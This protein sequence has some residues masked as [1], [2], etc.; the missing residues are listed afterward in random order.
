MRRSEKCLPR[1]GESGPRPAGATAPPAVAGGLW[2]DSWIREDLRSG[3]EGA[4]PK[5][6]RNRPT[7]GEP[8]PPSGGESGHWRRGTERTKS[9]TEKGRRQV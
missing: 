4:R 2:N 9:A 5:G 6:E 3:G 7:G 8:G 1:G